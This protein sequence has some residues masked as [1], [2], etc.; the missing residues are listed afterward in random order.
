VFGLVKPTTLRGHYTRQNTGSIALINIRL[1]S[2]TERGD[3]FKS[4]A[5]TLSG[6]Y[7]PESEGRELFELEIKLDVIPSDIKSLQKHQ[8]ILA[9]FVKNIQQ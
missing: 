9:K 6:W 8:S 4:V 5:N 3:P 7:T 1:S 2:I